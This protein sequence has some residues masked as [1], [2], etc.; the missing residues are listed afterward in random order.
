MRNHLFFLALI[1]PVTNCQL[2]NTSN[3]NDITLDPFIVE[4]YTN[5][6]KLLYFDEVFS[7][8]THI[9]FSNPVLDTTQY[10]QIL[11]IIQAVYNL[12]S[13]ERDLV[14][15]THN[16]HARYCY[17]FNSFYMKVNP[18]A[19]E[20]QNLVNGIIPTGNEMLDNLLTVYQI[21]S[22]RT[23]Y[24]YPTFPW[25]SL[26]S[27]EEYNMIPIAK[28]FEETEP[29]LLAEINYGCAGDGNTILLNRKND[30]QATITFSVGSGD[31]PSGCINR[32]S[33]EFEVI[34]N[35]ALFTRYYQR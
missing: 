27:S 10:T 25:F 34:N 12:D 20:I 3:S 7:D 15:L 22:V 18:E 28:Q 31:C 30:K 11:K 1:L 17:S 2:I 13:P 32:K 26:F 5:D 33:W 9:N 19:S 16:I 24:S 6:V 29:V 21:D 8:S 35:R 23:S 4:N 14:F